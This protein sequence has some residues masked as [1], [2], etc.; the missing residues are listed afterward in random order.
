MAVKEIVNCGGLAAKSPLLMQ[1]YADITGR[2]MKV[3]RSDQTPALGAAL[4]AAV[5]AGTFP[6]IEAARDAL[7]GTKLEY[8]PNQKHHKIYQELFN[9]YSQ[10]HDGFGTPDWSGNMRN[11][12]KELLDI[13]DEQ[14]KQ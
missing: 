7:T 6:D 13:R 2:P 1:I 9:L 5:A 3:S 8:A 12:M 11:V 4:F 14:R 10:L